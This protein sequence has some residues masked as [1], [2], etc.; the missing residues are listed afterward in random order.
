MLKK[1]FP[2]YHIE[3]KKL[4]TDELFDDGSHII[5]VN[6]QYN[7]QD[8]PIGKLMHDFRCTNA[9]DM[10]YGQLADK[11]KYYKEIGNCKSPQ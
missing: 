8:N 1:G 5:F 9:E 11:V 6:G 4:E 3:R 7:N 2:I 10:Y